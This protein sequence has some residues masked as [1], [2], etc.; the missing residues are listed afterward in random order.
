MRFGV[1][2]DTVSAI[3]HL[4][5]EIWTGASE[6]THQEKSRGHS[7]TPEQGQK[8]RRLRRIWPVVEGECDAGSIRSV[9]QGGAKKL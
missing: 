8:L 3:G 9:V 2:A 6:A 5:Y 4:A 1:V 7:V